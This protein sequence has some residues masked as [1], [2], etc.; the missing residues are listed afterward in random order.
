M[1]G[2]AT[3]VRNVVPAAACRTA[4]RIA[5]RSVI[6]DA[7]EMRLLLAEDERELAAWLVK[8]LAQSGLQVDWVDDGRLVL[9]SLDATRYDALILDWMRCARAAGHVLVLRNPPSGLASLATLYDI[10]GLL[11]L[12]GSA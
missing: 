2:W 11:P 8:A 12:E 4:R 10:D 3:A 9:P 5:G 7:C 1:Q 6:E